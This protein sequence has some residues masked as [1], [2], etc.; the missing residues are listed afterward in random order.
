MWIGTNTTFRVKNNTWQKFCISFCLHGV[1]YRP[2]IL[3]LSYLQFIV[4]QMMMTMMILKETTILM[5]MGML[6]TA[7]MT[8][9]KVIE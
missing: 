6:M 2:Q 8:N 3:I 5:M 1:R 9:V 7:L 4:T